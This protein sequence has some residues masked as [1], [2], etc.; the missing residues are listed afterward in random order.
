MAPR[1]EDPISGA[2]RRAPLGLLAPREKKAEEL[3]AAPK[4]EESL[5]PSFFG[6]TTRFCGLGEGRGGA[7]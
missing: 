1:G 4:K 3:M 6:S 7:Q 2:S 5:C